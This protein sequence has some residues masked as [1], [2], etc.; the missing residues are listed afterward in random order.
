MPVSGP[1]CIRPVLLGIIVILFLLGLSLSPS[2]YLVVAGE[3][4]EEL[5]SL[6]LAK[7]ESFKLY[8]EH[9]VHR[10]PVIEIFQV[11]PQGELR[12][13]ASEFS[14]FGVGT[15]FLPE[16]GELREVNGRFVL[17]GLERVFPEVRIRPLALTNNQLWYREQVY[18][19]FDLSSDGSVII[20]RV[21][22]GK[23]T[24]LW[25]YIDKGGMVDEP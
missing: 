8:Y 16:E 25:Q 24:K 10:T 11:G 22:P 19:L 21:C 18:P 4:G 1:K 5:M 2:Y 3:P 6:P 7:G 15:P 14:A 13:V 20:L 23:L 17:E 9:S 12:L